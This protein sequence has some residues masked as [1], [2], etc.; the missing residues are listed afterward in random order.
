MDDLQAATDL[1]NE[2]SRRY[3]GVADAT[4]DEARQ[5]WESPDVELETDVFVAEAPDGSLL[6]YGDIGERGAA[7]WLDVRGSQP[8]PQRAIIEALEDAARKKNT[9]ASLIGYLTEKDTT[10]R[11]LYDELGYRVVR[12]SYRMEV[13]LTGDVPEPGAPDS[14]VLRTMREGEEKEAYEVHQESFEDAWMFA[15]EPYGQWLHWFVNDPVFD[16][17]LWFFAEADG[18]IAGV[19]LC[20]VWEAEPGLGWIRVLGVR[21]PYRRRG[22]GEALLRY[23]F[24]E[25]ARRGFDRVGLGVDAASPTGAVSLY[26]RAGMHVVRTNLQYEKVQG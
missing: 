4:L 16:P 5:Y 18:E 15:R 19:A 24:A 23:A 12:H 11:R 21:S 3:H 20:R 26:E 1:F 7:L 9:G 6:A 14:V 22:I 17:S 13:E 8:E 2:H 10:L 25:F